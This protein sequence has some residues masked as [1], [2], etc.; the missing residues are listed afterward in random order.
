ML[1]GKLRTF[2]KLLWYNHFQPISFNFIISIKF[3]YFYY[4]L[5]RFI[6]YYYYFLFFRF[7]V[8]LFLT[9]DVPFIV[10][11]RVFMYAVVCE[12]ESV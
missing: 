11:V 6:F 8:Y 3:V 9:F 12:R 7:S 4:L 5:L 1:P 10:K 2:I